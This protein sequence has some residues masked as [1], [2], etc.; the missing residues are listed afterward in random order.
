[1]TPEHWEQA[2]LLHR[3]ALQHEESRPA[4]FLY[5]ACA[6]D[7]DLRREVESLLDYEEKAENFMELPWRWW[8]TS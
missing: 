8:P 5:A 7:E 6:G 4:A 3:A 2:A 1:V